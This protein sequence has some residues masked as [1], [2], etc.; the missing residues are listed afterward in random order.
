MQ[1]SQSAGAVH[2]ICSSA[3]LL[4]SN[5]L[6]GGFGNPVDVCIRK[7]IS[8]IYMAGIVYTNSGLLTSLSG[9]SEYHSP[10]MYVTGELVFPSPTS[11]QP[12]TW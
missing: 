12:L 3:G 6:V 2:D 5:M 4:L 9:F 8:F 11:F 7:V 1:S 10:G